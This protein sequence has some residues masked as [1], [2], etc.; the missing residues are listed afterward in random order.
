M[1]RAGPCRS[2]RESFGVG[3]GDGG[4]APR[5]PSCRGASGNRSRVCVSRSAMARMSRHPSL[6]S[7]LLRCLWNPPFEVQPLPRWGAAGRG[8]PV[9]GHKPRSFRP[10]KCAPEAPWGPRSH[11][12]PIQTSG[13]STPRAEGPTTRPAPHSQAQPAAP[14]TSRGCVS[15]A[16]KRGLQ[17]GGEAEG[18][19]TRV[20]ESGVGQGG[21]R[22]REV[23]FSEDGVQ[24]VGAGVE[25]TEANLTTPP[26]G[27]LTPPDG[28]R[29]W[30]CGGRGPEQAVASLRLRAEE[31]G[32][33]RVSLSQPWG[34]S[35]PRRPPPP[36]PRAGGTGRTRGRPET[37]GA[38][39]A[40]VRSDETWPV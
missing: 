25:T 27:M 38:H 31:S 6:P 28:W 2:A 30:P 10:S 1:P 23:P 40:G 14:A 15:S 17:A 29:P 4:A 33:R 16:R 8:S 18:P 19:P 7:L 37:P 11:A 13:D 3:G 39:G 36:A 12:S 35:P 21:R 9:H 26:Q 22:A 24:G 5:P 20:G 32:G 34:S